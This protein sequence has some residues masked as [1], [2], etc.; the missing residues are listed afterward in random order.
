MKNVRNTLLLLMLVI[1]VLASQTPTTAAPSKSPAGPPATPPTSPPD[2]SLQVHPLHYAPGPLD[3]PLKGFMPYFF[4][5]TDYATAYPHSMEWSYFALSEI[6]SD[7]SNCSNY[8][9]EMVEQML[10]EVGSRGNQTTMRFYMEYPGGTGTHPGNGVPPC[11]NGHV[12]MRTNGFWGTVSPDYDSPFLLSAVG[13]F[14]AA[15]GA[16]Y[17]G[18]KRIASIHMGLVG[19]WGEWHTWPYDRDTADGYPNLFPTDASVNTI[20]D[21]YAAAFHKTP[22]EIRYAS[23]GYSGPTD[24]SGTPANPHTLSANVG[25]HDDSWCYKEFRS[26]QGNGLAHSMTLPISM[27]GWGDAFLQGQLYIGAENKW[28]TNY[29]SGE[30]RPEIQ[31]SLFSGGG[32]VDNWKDCIEMTHATSMI[33]Q[34][35]VNSYNAGDATVA[36]GVREMGYNFSV[37]NA[38]FNNVNPGD[39][40]K[41]G[42]QM[43]NDGVAPFY[44]GPDSWP[45]VIGA[46]DGSGNVVKTWT[47]TW[48]LRKVMPQ[49]IRAFPDWNVGANPTYRSFGQP[50]Y[51][52]ASFANPGL[53]GG[54]YTLVMR[55]RNPLE[56]LSEAAVRAAGHIQTY[57]VWSAPKKLRFA[58]QEQGSDG[59]VS[60]GQ[61]SIGGPVFTLT[62][63]RPASA[64]PTKTPFSTS[65]PPTATNTSVPTTAV[66]TNTPTATAVPGTTYEAEA[67]A[68]TLAGGAVVA[69]CSPCSNGQKVGYVGNNAG[70]LQFNSISAPSAGSYTVTIYFV[71]GDSGVRTAQMSVNGGSAVTLSFPVT[72]GWTTVS[73]VTQTVTLNVGSSNTIKFS[74]TTAGSWAP[75]FD[76]IVVNTTGAT[77]AP[78]TAVPTTAVPTF[79]PPTNTTVPTFQPPT[80]TPVPTTAVPTNTPGGAA[81]SIDAFSDQTRWSNKLNDL[82]QS[83]SWSMDSLYYGTNPPGEIVMNSG[84]T[85]QYYQENINQSLSG[86][87]SLIVR[88]R[89]WN[90]GSGTEQH[91]NIVL[92]D[93]ADHSVALSNYGTASGSYQNFTIALSAFGANLANAKY[94]RIVHKD[95]TYAV[96]LVD[97]ISV[98]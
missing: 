72:G 78:T 95:T 91:W 57:Q 47:T 23:P 93:G 61:I 8:N 88:L 34:T 53:S 51:F 89:D 73:T 13:N 3:N 19:L 52:G 16:R 27:D 63:T 21:A 68:N 24:S 14:I 20:I 71:N 28:I 5:G 76:R 15:F 96:L 87:S 94:V 98:Q 86:R 49:Q 4:K 29:I 81:L 50:Y 60:L 9:W 90:S 70:T 65:V 2:P 64:T 54:T 35:G 10:D 79:A 37:T 66:P 18:D 32:Q 40:L 55:V 1:L 42:V 62:P 83:L 92:N 84:G 30:V 69:A 26:G 67:S 36:A 77:P 11:F 85:N 75:D 39:P 12:T 31:G 7:A 41:V 59:W 48:D 46:K 22:I 97:A 17:D 58:N 82:N 43:M 74:N 6:M 38:Y 45:V 33:N 25:Y 56:D 44:Y 80:N